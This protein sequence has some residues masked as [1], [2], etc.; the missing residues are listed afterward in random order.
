MVVPT[1]CAADKRLLIVA[2]GNDMYDVREESMTAT[3]PVPIDNTAPEALAVSRMPAESAVLLG[4]PSI[5]DGDVGGLAAV[6]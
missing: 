5:S 4:F 6:T 2:S 3:P 1:G